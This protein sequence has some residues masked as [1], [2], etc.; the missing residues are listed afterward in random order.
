MGIPKSLVQTK[1]WREAYGIELQVSI[2][3]SPI[4][5]RMTDQQF[6]SW[7]SMIGELNLP[8]SALNIEIT[9]GLLLDDSPAVTSKLHRFREKGVAISIDDFGTGYSSLAYLRKFDIDYLKIDRQFIKGMQN[10]E[11]DI[12][13]CQAIISMAHSLG[14]EVIAEGIENASQL[15]LLKQED[16]DMGQGFFI[17]EAVTA[18]EFSGNFWRDDYL[19]DRLA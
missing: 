1:Y 9:E 14:I 5:F 12:A 6:D 2:N 8:G 15:R 16:C 10:N 18:A 17:S 4:Q 13:L 7:L 11:D 3:M 19:N